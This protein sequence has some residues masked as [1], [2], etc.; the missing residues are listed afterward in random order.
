[1]IKLT[2]ILT[3][4]LNA[5]YAFADWPLIHFLKCRIT[6]ADTTVVGYFT[7]PFEGMPDSVLAKLKMDRKYFESRVLKRLTTIELNSFTYIHYYINE[8]NNSREHAIYKSKDRLILDV[9]SI[10]KIE[11]LE[12]INFQFV[13]N[14]IV[15]KVAMPDTLWMRKPVLKIYQDKDQCYPYRFLV[16]DDTIDYEDIVA[17]VMIESDKRESVVTGLSSYKILGLRLNNCN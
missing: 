9:K 13:P 12:V 17:K 15:T 6:T 14:V 11:L 8:K 1:M 2:L 7:A 10:N 5:S 3:I 4:V 16:Y